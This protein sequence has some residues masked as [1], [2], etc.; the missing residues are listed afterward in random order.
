MTIQSVQNINTKNIAFTSAENEK[1]SEGLSVGRKIGIGATTALGVGAALVGMAKLNKFPIN[2]KTL[3][4]TPIKDTF[5][6]KQEYFEKEV[7]AMGLGSCAGGLAGGAIFDKK[8][9]L[10][11]KKREAVVQLCNATT[12]ILFVGAGARLVDKAAPA[13]KKIVKPVT[14][15]MTLSAGMK[16]VIGVTPKIAASLAGLAVG[17]LAGNKLSHIINNKLFGEK[18]D[19]P[20]SIKDLCAHTDDMCEM[21]SFIS[22]TNP[23]IHGVSRIIPVAMLVPGIETGKAQAKD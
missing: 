12:P 4:K 19:R 23:V 6:N 14:D 16:K 17:M 7:I 22:T 20:V 11:A 10:P 15:K 21:A 5:L 13:L 3:L 18:E 2:P 9:N 1:K 8:E